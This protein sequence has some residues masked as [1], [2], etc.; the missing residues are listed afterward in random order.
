MAHEMEYGHGGFKEWF[1][2]VDKCYRHVVLSSRSAV[3]IYTFAQKWLEL[4]DCYHCLDDDQVVLHRG[5]VLH[6]A[7]AQL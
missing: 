5:G 1:Y 7:A 4:G 6:M 3:R 2:S